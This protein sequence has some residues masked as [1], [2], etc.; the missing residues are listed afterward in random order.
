MTRIGDLCFYRFKIHRRFTLCLKTV[1]AGRFFPSA[2]P[3]SLLSLTVMLHEEYVA[4]QPPQIGSCP[5]CSVL[6]IYVLLQYQIFYFQE[7]GIQKFVL[8]YS[9]VN[10]VL[11]YRK[12]RLC[13]YPQRDANKGGRHSSS[14]YSLCDNTDLE[15][16]TKVENSVW[17]LFSVLDCDSSETEWRPCWKPGFI[18]RPE[19][20]RANQVRTKK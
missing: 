10:L 8:H 2:L 3:N 14:V 13:I 5:T 11:Y 17:S 18:V 16:V 15:G 12:T 6:Y 19:T 7:G 1:K 20:G 9:E 4:D